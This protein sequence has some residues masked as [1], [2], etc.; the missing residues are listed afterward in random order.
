M[1]LTRGLLAG[2]LV[3]ELDDSLA[4]G[5]EE[6]S[7]V[8]ISFDFWDLAYQSNV[9]TIITTIMQYN[10]ALCTRALTVSMLCFAKWLWWN[11]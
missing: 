10:V 7:E 3:E 11:T 9:H 8:D 5:A 2:V 1:E 4:G 6:D